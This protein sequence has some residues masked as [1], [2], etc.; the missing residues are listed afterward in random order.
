[1]ADGAGPFPIVEDSTDLSPELR[2]LLPLGTL[3]LAYQVLVHTLRS[4]RGLLFIE[5]SR[6]IGLTWALAAYCVLR[7]ARSKS[8]GGRNQLYISYAFDMTRE[9]IDYCAM[10]AKAFGLAASRPEEFLFE[11]QDPDGGESRHIKAFRIDFASRFYIRALSSAPRS[12]RGKQ[13]DVI[14]DEG[15]FV[16]NLPALLDAAIALTI[17]GGDVTVVSSHFGVDNAFNEEIQK[18]R[19]GERKGRVHTITF[20]Q[21]IEDGLYER[22]CLVSGQTP[23]PEGKAKFIDDT[24]GQY[25]AGSKQELDCIPA[26]SGGSWLSF[27]LI[28]RAEQPGVPV[29]RLACDDAF[30]H[31]PDLIRRA[32]VQEWCD[33]HLGPALEALDAR[34]IGVGDDFARSSDLSV[35][36]LLRESQDRS[37]DTPF[38]VELRNVPFEEQLFIRRY[39]LT[40]LRRWRCK[41]DAHGNGA[42]TAERLGQLFGRSRVEGVKWRADDWR[43][44]GAPLKARFEDGRI[45]IP[46]DADLA[47]DIRQVQVID[48]APAIPAKRTRAKGEE[49]ATAAGKALRHADGAVALFKASAAL[50]AGVIA[51]FDSASLGSTG[52]PAAFFGDADLGDFAGVLNLNGY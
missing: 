13:G 31:K 35:I 8:E 27:D 48:G 50:R 20:R 47:S 3:L 41:I 2:P 39:I 42:S 43:D 51:D 22:V 1:M 46:R 23:T 16:D 28:D 33:T 6:R 25:G 19:A 7:A 38:V 32:S 24:Y 29:F 14:V 40:R 4:V 45:T 52:A 26:R 49:A 34:A 44:E 11:D 36:W 18:I 10:W 5:K 15:A 12:L 37:W 17:W 30:T 9:F 21:A